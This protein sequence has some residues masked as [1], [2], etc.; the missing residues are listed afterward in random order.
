MSRPSHVIYRN[1]FPLV[2]APDLHPTP[3]RYLLEKPDLPLTLPTY[4]ILR[5]TGTEGGVVGIPERFEDSPDAEN[6]AGGISQMGRDNPAISR[7]G[8]FVMWGF[9][10]DPTEFTENGVR[11]F[12]NVIAY[13]HAHRGERP[14]VRHL[15]TPR[16]YAHGNAQ[17]WPFVRYLGYQVE[18]DAD[19][20][21]VGLANDSF[22]LLLW[23]AHRLASNPGDLVATRL[24]ERY[25]PIGPDQD[26]ESW[27]NEHRSRLFFSDWG[28]FRWFLRP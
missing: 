11:L 22:E 1:P 10:G 3:A 9:H 7:Q 28:G 13:A 6:I 16:E 26:L 23:I 25:L 15:G 20:K 2:G 24:R 5:K 8:S 19:A 18:I 4:E 17:D 12:L 21:A 27:L 14:L